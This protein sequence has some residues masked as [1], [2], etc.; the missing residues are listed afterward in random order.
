MRVSIAV[1][2]VATALV[3]CQPAGAPRENAQIEAEVSARVEGYL[4]AIRDLDL[5]YMEDFWADVDGFTVAGDGALTVG[6]DPWI[7]QLRTLV[8]SIESVAFVEVTDPQVY[9]LGADAAS[10][11]MSYRWSFNMTDGSVLSATGSWM[12]VMRRFADGWRVVHSAGSHIY[13]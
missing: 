13:S 7:E 12:Y 6:Y 5:P 9:V 8:A 2:V 3:A 4:Q 10:Y 1:T 11:S